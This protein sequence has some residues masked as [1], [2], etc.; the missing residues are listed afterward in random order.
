MPLFGDNQPRANPG[1]G[2]KGF[3]P[4]I[5]PTRNYY[6][7]EDDGSYKLVERDAPLPFIGRVDRVS[8]GNDLLDGGTDILGSIGQLL[9]L[10]RGGRGKLANQAPPAIQRL[11]S[12][13]NQPKPLSKAGLKK[14]VLFSKKGLVALASK[15]CPIIY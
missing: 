6:K 2:A 12:A 14:L 10:M 11:A 3:W 13:A 8:T 4:S 7:L 15:S 9:L 5:L 1:F